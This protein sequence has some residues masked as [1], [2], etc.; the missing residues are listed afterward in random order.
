MARPLPVREL[1]LYV[2]VF[3]EVHACRCSCRTQSC[4]KWRFPDLLIRERNT[5]ADTTDYPCSWLEILFAMVPAEHSLPTLSALFLIRY[6]IQRAQA[7]LLWAETLCE[8]TTFSPRAE[9]QQVS[10][11]WLPLMRDSKNVGP[12]ARLEGFGF[13]NFYRFPLFQMVWKGIKTGWVNKQGNREAEWHLHGRWQ[14]E[15]GGSRKN[16]TRTEVKMTLM[17]E[18]NR[19]WWPRSW[20]CN[21]QWKGETLERLTRVNCTEE[22]RPCTEISR[23]LC[24]HFLM[25]W[26]RWTHGPHSR[27]QKSKSKVLFCFPP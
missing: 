24:D 10:L 14:Q 25:Q 8:N 9:G 26:R 6:Y 1:H 23:Q 11:W 16:G 22:E 13:S 4:G 19:Q 5:A 2:L 12:V 20:K 17:G 3:A 18:N 15:S 21:R 27:K 7:F